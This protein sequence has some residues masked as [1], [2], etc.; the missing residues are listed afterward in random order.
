M[1]GGG[2]AGEGK[3]PSHT[4]VPSLGKASRC[5]PCAGGCVALGPGETAERQGQD[6]EKKQEGGI[7]TAGW[8]SAPLR[9]GRW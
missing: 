2:R 7:I 4:P 8:Q 3:S 9:T 5:L 1:R 6:L